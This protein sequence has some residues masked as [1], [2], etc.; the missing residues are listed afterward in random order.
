MKKSKPVKQFFF[1]D[2]SAQ[3]MV[4]ILN[5]CRPISLKHNEDLVNTTRPSL[6]PGIL[7]GSSP[8]FYQKWLESAIKYTLIKFKKEEQ[9]I[10]I[11]AWN[12]WG[13]GAV[14]EPCNQWGKKYLEATLKARKI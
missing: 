6:N 13:E 12:E 3:G 1:K 14:L 4:D 11:N 9:L 5:Q 10:F 7:Y 8:L 2:I